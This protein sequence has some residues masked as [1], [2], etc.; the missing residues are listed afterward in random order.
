MAG[1]RFDAGGVTIDRTG[2]RR[3]HAPG[4]LVGGDQQQPHLYSEPGLGPP[5][6]RGDLATIVTCVGSRYRSAWPVT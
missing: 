2:V 1:S 3:C 4:N 6:E 5:L